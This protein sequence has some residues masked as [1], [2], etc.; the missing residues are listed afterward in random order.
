VFVKGQFAFPPISPIPGP[1][2]IRL[3]YLQS[4]CYLG[5]CET[6]LLVKLNGE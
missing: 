3:A 5:I 2:P 4:L 1:D 6:F